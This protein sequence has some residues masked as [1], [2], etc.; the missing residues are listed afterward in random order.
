MPRTYLTRAETALS[1]TDELVE[2][3]VD[4]LESERDISAFAR[5]SNR[6]YCI[7]D[8]LL[9]RRNI[10]QSAGSALNVGR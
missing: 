9:Y 6:F 8:P 3:I 7:L 4:G 5:T 2:I 10:Q 1:L